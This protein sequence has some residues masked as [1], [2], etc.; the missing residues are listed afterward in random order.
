VDNVIDAQRIDE[1][2]VTVG[3]PIETAAIPAWFAMFASRRHGFDHDNT[4]D[5][6]D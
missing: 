3:H 2:S 4:Q 5:L 1:R 6:L